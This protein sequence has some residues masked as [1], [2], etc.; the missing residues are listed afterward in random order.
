MSLFNL[1]NLSTI[2]FSCDLGHQELYCVTWL[3]QVL[4]WCLQKYEQ[5]H[6]VGEKKLDYPS[7]IGSTKLHTLQNYLRAELAIHG[8][9]LCPWQTSIWR[10]EQEVHAG[11]ARWV[12]QAQAQ[13]L[14]WGQTKDTRKLIYK[15]SELPLNL[16]YISWVVLLLKF[17][18][19]AHVL[20]LLHTETEC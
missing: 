7:R 10:Q 5:R 19:S 6:Q 13:R 17:S 9:M 1:N 18:W 3:E 2:W 16:F 15:P 14:I 11:S 4:N 20:S 8:C 12:V